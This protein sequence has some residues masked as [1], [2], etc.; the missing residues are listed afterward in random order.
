MEEDYES[1]YDAPSSTKS[2]ANEFKKIFKLTRERR[3]KYQNWNKN[4]NKQK[5]IDFE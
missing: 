1:N 4:K 5:I 3:R 2:K